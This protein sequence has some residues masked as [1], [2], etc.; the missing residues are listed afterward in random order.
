M[1]I[2]LKVDQ[3]LSKKTNK[4][5]SKTYLIKPVNSGNLT[6]SKL[7]LKVVATPGKPSDFG[8]LSINDVLTLECFNPT[9]TKPTGT[10][11][12]PYLLLPAFLVAL[13]WLFII[14]LG[15]V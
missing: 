7:A 3:I 4:V 13:M 12:L 1:E 2:E 6:C 14:W 5:E 8:E 10:I 11:V 9:S 15:K